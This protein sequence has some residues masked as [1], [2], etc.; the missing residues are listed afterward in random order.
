MIHSLEKEVE[1]HP[2]SLPASNGRS[3]GEEVRRMLAESVWW[4]T[5]PVSGFVPAVHQLFT[6]FGRLEVVHLK[7]AI[8]V[9]DC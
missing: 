3:A 1:S 5:S 6:P 9:R 4:D 7:D 2:F 8:A